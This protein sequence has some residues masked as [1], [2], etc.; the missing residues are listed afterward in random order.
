MNRTSIRDSLKV[1]PFKPFILRVT[2]GQ[3]FHVLDPDD[4]AISPSQ[5]IVIVFTTDHYYVLDAEKVSSI[6]VLP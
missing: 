1:R 6:E 3:Q 5:P 4:I 2:D